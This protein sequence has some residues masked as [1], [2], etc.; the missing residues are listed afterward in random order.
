MS[1]YTAIVK[2]KTS[3]YSF[4]LPVVLAMNMAGIKDPELFEGA[5]T[6]LLEIGHYFTVTDDFL[7]CFGDPAVSVSMRF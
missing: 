5:K 3:Y 7:D 2:Y 4:Y 1:R 6:I